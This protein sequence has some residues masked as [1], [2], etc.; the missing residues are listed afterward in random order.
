MA[1]AR[2]AVCICGFNPNLCRVQRNRSAANRTDCH[3]HQR[4]R[5]LFPCRKQHIHFSAAGLGVDFLCL[6]NQAVCCLALCGQYNHNVIPFHSCTH[7]ALCNIKHSFGICDGTAAV[8]LHNQHRLFPPV[9]LSNF[10]WRNYSLSTLAPTLSACK[11]CS[12]QLCGRVPRYADI[13]LSNLSAFSFV[14]IAIK[15]EPAPLK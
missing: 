11:S 8:F 13:S 5:L 7:D 6:R 2:I 14:T 15:V 12:F 1:D 9:L 4:N 10:P 3:C